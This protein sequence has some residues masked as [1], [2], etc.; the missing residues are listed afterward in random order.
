M[1]AQQTADPFP[2]EVKRLIKERG[3]TMRG[4]AA[5]ASIDPGLLV[6][7]LQGKKRRSP[8]VIAAVGAAL[9]LPP[10]YSLEARANVLT[11]LMEKDPALVNELYYRVPTTRILEA[12]DESKSP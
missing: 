4:L 6:R 1:A 7:A 5:E 8:N 9:G 2:I 3:L 12:T 11:V 10:F